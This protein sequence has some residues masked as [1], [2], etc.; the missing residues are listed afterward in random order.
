MKSNSI[1]ISRDIPLTARLRALELWVSKSGELTIIASQFGPKQ[2]IPKLSMG[3]LESLC[4]Q[5][6]FGGLSRQNSIADIMLLNGFLT[7]SQYDDF[8]FSLEENLNN[9]NMTI[10]YSEL[11]Q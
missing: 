1:I 8:Y 2:P 7:R 10:I 11:F 5:F 4:T 3:Y 6:Y 9:G